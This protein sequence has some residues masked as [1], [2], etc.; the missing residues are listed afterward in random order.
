MSVAKVPC[1]VRFP[2]IMNT[3]SGNLEVEAEIRQIRHREEAEKTHT[4][5]LTNLKKTRPSPWFA[6]ALNVHNWTYSAIA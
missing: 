1:A 6:G 5:Y 2:F 3:P 4:Y